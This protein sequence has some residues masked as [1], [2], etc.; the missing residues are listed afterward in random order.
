MD[1]I[2]INN[3]NIRGWKVVDNRSNTLVNKFNN[4]ELF[5]FLNCIIN[6]KETNNYFITDLKYDF[7]FTPIG[8]YEKLKNMFQK[9]DSDKNL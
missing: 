3:I 7:F 8:I 4:Q 5:Y 9:K 2:F 1:K 6:R